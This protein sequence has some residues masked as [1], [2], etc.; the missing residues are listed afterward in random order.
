MAL[1]SYRSTNTLPIVATYDSPQHLE[2]PR[3]SSVMRPTPTH[4]ATPVTRAGDTRT[5]AGR[6]AIALPSLVT[7]PPTT[8]PSPRRNPSLKTSLS[9]TTAPTSRPS[10]SRTPLTEAI[11]GALRRLT[12]KPFSNASRTRLPPYLPTAQEAHI[13][14]HPSHSGLQAAR[15][16]VTQ[17]YHTGHLSLRLTPSCTPSGPPS[18]DVWGRAEWRDKRLLLP[19]G[20]IAFAVTVAPS[21]SRPRKRRAPTPMP[22][23]RPSQPTSSLSTA[24]ASMTATPT[25]PTPLAVWARIVAPDANNPPTSPLLDSAD[26]SQCIEL[27]FEAAAN[28]HAAYQAWNPATDLHRRWSNAFPPLTR[29]PSTSEDNNPLLSP[30][31]GK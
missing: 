21:A 25:A 13:L 5:R 7:P 31:S 22:P 24:Y 14:L 10:N 12:D 4:H 29:L 28:A 9:H 23:A 6:Y 1:R 3:P 30:E 11:T 27:S 18:L 15:A 20:A 26:F 8:G 17:L 2:S 19:S 16:L